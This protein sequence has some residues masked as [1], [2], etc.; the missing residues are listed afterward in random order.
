[1]LEKQHASGVFTCMKEELVLMK[2]S[3]TSGAV[4]VNLSSAFAPWGVRLSTSTSGDRGD[5]VAAMTRSTAKHVGDRGIRVVCVQPRM[6]DTPL[7]TRYR[8]K[9]GDLLSE[10]PLGRIASANEIAEVIL[11]LCDSSKAS[12][13]TGCSVPVHGGAEG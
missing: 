12:Y 5:M 9:H 10:C 1:M 3:A 7:L 13:M 11:F 4:V 2:R 6:V 8:K